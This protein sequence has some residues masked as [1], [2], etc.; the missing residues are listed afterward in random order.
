M[1]PQFTLERLGR[2]ETTEYDSELENL[3]EQTDKIKTS[4]ERILNCAELILQPNPGIVTIDTTMQS[5]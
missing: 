1:S 3:M 5:P 2:A 4:T